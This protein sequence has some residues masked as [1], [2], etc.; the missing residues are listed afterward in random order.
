MRRTGESVGTMTHYNADS[1]MNL[2]YLD[3]AERIDAE[4]GWYS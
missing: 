1:D 4:A 3:E 2:E